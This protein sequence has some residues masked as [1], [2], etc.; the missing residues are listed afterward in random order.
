MI[1]RC[2][3]FAFCIIAYIA[4]K[5]KHNVRLKQIHA[6]T[7]IYFFADFAIIIVNKPIKAGKT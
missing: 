6:F 3:F 4:K 7:N 1:L 2:S 5:I